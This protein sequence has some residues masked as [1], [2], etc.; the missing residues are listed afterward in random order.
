MSIT[1]YKRFK[2]DIDLRGIPSVPRLP[3]GYFWVPWDEAL[4]DLHAEVHYQ[5]FC[6]A[7]D[8]RLFPTFGDRHACTHLIREIRRKPGFLAGATWL[9]ACAEGC[10]G[11]V[12]GVVERFG[13]GSIQN[14]GIVPEHRNRGLGQALIW[15]ALHGFRDY[16]LRRAYLEVTAENE[17]ALRLYH[18]LGFRKMKTLYKAVDE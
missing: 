1:Y 14:V 6:S 17:G 13:Y 10:C 5:A 9:I 8:V 3:D 16:H 18:R 4:L 12:Q 2:M 7:V 15:Q 11:S